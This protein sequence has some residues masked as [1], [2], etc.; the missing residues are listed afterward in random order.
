M[1]QIK[2]N[3]LQLLDLPIEI[4]ERIVFFVDL[5]WGQTESDEGYP[6]EASLQKCVK[7]LLA[8]SYTI[9]MSAAVLGKALAK[10]D[11]PLELCCL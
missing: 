7:S 5:I 2:P 4:L 9:L 3:P 1:L 8:M 6:I 10:S 11:L